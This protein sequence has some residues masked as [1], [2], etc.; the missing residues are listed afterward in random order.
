MILDGFPRNLAQAA[1]LDKVLAGE[2]ASKLDAVIELKVDDNQ[3]IQRI[4]AASP[5]PSAARAINDKK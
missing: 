5:A 1:A 3:L 2:E 4:A